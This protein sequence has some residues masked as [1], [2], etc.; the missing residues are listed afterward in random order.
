MK[1]IL[2]IILTFFITSIAAQ[3]YKDQI[4]V[5]QFSAPFT[6]T[7]EISLK[8]FSDHNTH[9]FHITEKQDIFKKENITYLPTIILFHN[10]KEIVRIES[11]ISL[12]LPEDTL[13]VINDH[14]D[15]ILANKF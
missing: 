4:S 14:I 13:D 5:V 10:G 6:E 3:D 11:G 15:N 8:K 9:T 12:K 7:A 2:A 1:H